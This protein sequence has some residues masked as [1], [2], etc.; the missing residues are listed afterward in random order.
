MISK[1]LIRTLQRQKWVSVGDYQMS[2]Q[3]LFHDEEDGLIVVVVVSDT[4]KRFP[5]RMKS[6]FLRLGNK[7][8]IAP[9]IIVEVHQKKKPQQSAVQLAIWAPGMPITPG[10]VSDR[11]MRVSAANAGTA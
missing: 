5:R 1:P 9:G 8:T 3:G 6:A 4:T 2:Y 11:R 7:V 10:R